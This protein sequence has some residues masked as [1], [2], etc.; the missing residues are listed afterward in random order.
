MADAEGKG[1]YKIIDIEITGSYKKNYNVGEKFENVGMIVNAIYTDGSKEEIY[2]YEYTQDALQEGDNTITVTYGEFSK[3][4]TVS[5]GIASVDGKWVSKKVYIITTAAIVI[6]ILL[7][8]ALASGIIHMNKKMQRMFNAVIGSD[9][10]AAQS[11]E[12]NRKEH[13][14]D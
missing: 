1:E 2:D 6:L 7:C 4:I 9:N 11:E 12:E 8:I 5:A 10:D 14:E 3:S 13:N